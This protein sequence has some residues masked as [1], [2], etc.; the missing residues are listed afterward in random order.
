M[1]N[2]IKMMISADV[3]PVNHRC[4]ESLGVKRLS[5]NRWCV[6]G[7]PPQ[8]KLGFL[9][10]CRLQWIFIDARVYMSVLNTEHRVWVFGCGGCMR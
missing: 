1:P 9:K 6:L 8:S 10:N 3:V 4:G 5:L 7:T 2:F